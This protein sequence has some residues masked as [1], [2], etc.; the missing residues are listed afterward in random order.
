MSDISKEEKKKL[1]Q[2]L[3]EFRKQGLLSYGKYLEEQLEFASREK[4][5]KKYKKYIEDQIVANQKKI[6]KI[7][8]K[9]GLS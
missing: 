9:L 8:A 3:R 2:K 4:S 6:S 1:S 5:R 7:D